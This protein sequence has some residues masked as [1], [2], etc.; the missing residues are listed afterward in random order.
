MGLPLTDKY[1]HENASPSFILSFP[2]TLSSTH[3]S[4]HSSNLHRRTGSPEDVYS[5]CFFD[6]L[7]RGRFPTQIPDQIPPKPGR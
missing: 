4:T 3:S 2:S 7:T 5:V 6:S 1:A